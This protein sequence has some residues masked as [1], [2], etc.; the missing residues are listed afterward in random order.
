LASIGY[1]VGLIILP[2]IKSSGP[3]CSFSVWMFIVF[4]LYCMFLTASI[5][6]NTS[7]LFVYKVAVSRTV[8]LLYY[9]VS[10]VLAL[11]IPTPAYVTGQYGYSPLG[12]GCWFKGEGTTSAYIWAWASLYGW[13]ILI[14]VYCLVV[15]VR[16][17]I[18]V[19]RHRRKLAAAT[20]LVTHPQDKPNVALENSKGESYKIKRM[21]F[22]KEVL[23]IVSRI[24]YYPFIGII[25]QMFNLIHETEYVVSG[26]F[27]FPLLMLAEIGSGCQGILLLIAFLFDPAVQDAMDKS[28]EA[29]FI[30]S[31]FSE[32]ESALDEGE[33]EGEKPET[34][35]KVNLNHF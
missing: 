4:N 13:L 26:T 27:V 28:R 5:A 12:N 29:D 8:E 32:R 33:E 31:S 24:I 6:L 7:T 23:L 15:V 35:D 21:Q 20:R 11:I 17:V 9:G 14:I 19:H 16:V 10:L 2:S 3:K 18:G 34:W 30:A 25:C 22:L 1:S